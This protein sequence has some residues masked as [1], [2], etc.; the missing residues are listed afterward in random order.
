LSGRIVSRR[1]II[2]LVITLTLVVIASS[3]GLTRAVFSD[4]E[5]LHVRLQAGTWVCTYTMGYWKNHPEDWPVEEIKIGG[6]TH[7]KEDA[8]NILETP[9]EGDATYILA[10]QLIAAKLNVTNGADSNGLGDTIKN[11]DAW[12]TANI[13]G[14]DPTDP[15]RAQGIALAEMLDDFNNGLSGPSHC[16]D[17][18]LLLELV[19]T[20][21][22]ETCTFSMDY[23]RDHPDVWPAEAITIG[24]VTSTKAEAITI[25]E[26]APQGDTT[27]I[28]ASQLIPSVLNLLNGADGG[29]I[30]NAA[31]DADQW[32]EDHPLGSELN[33]EDRQAGFALADTLEEY[34]TGEIG[35]GACDDEVKTF[36]PTVTATST[37]ASRSISTMTP[38]ATETATATPTDIPIAI[39]TNTPT[40]TF[41]PTVTA[42]QTETPTATPNDTPVATSTNTPTDTFTP[43]VTATPT[44]TSTETP[45]PTDTPTATQIETST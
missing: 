23:W 40:E 11:A 22:P 41:T 15:A 33:E 38:T 34:N 12:L 17:E 19:E 18:I 30:E 37:E 21:N 28:L 44:E 3:V 24:G 25:L 9:P 14:S 20:P 26:Q 6:V 32:L 2:G 35:P 43:T 42:T 31:V 1:L 27:Y 29:T 4:S 45:T 36:T 39:S 7:T 16:E 5:S 10:H 8:I 13:L